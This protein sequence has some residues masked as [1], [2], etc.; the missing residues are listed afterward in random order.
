[1]LFQIY[2]NANNNF[3]GDVKYHRTKKMGMND[4]LMFIETEKI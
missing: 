1:M 2:Y 3:D 4:I